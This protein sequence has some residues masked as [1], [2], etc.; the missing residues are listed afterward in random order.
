MAVA[1]L[2]ASQQAAAAALVSAGRL[3]VVPVDAARAAA[4]LRQATNALADIPNVT[5]PQNQYNLA[6][7]A[8]H[9]VGES[10]LAAYGYRTASGPGQHQALGEFLK[11]VFDSP[12]GDTAARR[13]DTLRLSRNQQRYDA[14]P[15][16]SADAVVAVS[17]AQDLV[18][19]A[20]SRG[21]GT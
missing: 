19:A 21:V 6:Y 16:S 4:F 17:T 8:S 5:Q 3:A 20:E 7:D 9:D 13:F 14:R 10:A 2:S 12:P 18:A 15:I 1:P 11:V